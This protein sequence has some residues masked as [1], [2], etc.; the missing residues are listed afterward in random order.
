MK[1]LHFDIVDS[2]Q[3]IAN[4]LINNKIENILILADL[5]TAGRGRLNS[6]T[7]I[8]GFGNFMG[9][10][11]VNIKNMKENSPALLVDYTLSIIS[12]FITTKSGAVPQ[13]KAPNDV[14]VNNKKIAGVL[15]EIQFPYAI[16][17]IGFNT[18]NSP[19]PTSTNFLSEFNIAVSHQEFAHFINNKLRGSL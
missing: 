19:L 12:D 18:I 15:V 10:F 6:H 16:I 11:V 9:S 7:W 1:I 8:S 2:T 5:Q 3:N 17:G 4:N 14:L 13:V